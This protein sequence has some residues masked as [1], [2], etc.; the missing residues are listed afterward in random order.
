MEGILKLDGVD[1][2]LGAR[3]LEL[4]D[5][6]AFAF[7]YPGGVRGVRL[8]N[9]IGQLD[10][11]P[12]MGQQIWDA[13]FRGRRLTMRSM[14]SRP[15]KTGFFLHTYGCFM[16]H[17][18]ALRMGGP[19]PEDDHPLH[20]ELPCAGYR[21]AEL[22]F[23]EDDAGPWIAVSGTYEYDKAFQAH[24]TARPT[25]VLHAGSSLFDISLEISNRSSYPM[26]LM[27]MCHVNFV[28]VEG[29]RIVQST[30]WD[31]ESM[32]VRTSVPEHVSVSDE[33]LQFLEKLKTDPGLTRVLRSEDEYRPE[34]AFFMG[35]V[36]ADA[37]GRA[38]FLQVHP[39][40]TADY[41]SYRPGELDHATR[42]I[43][44]TG[45]QEALGLALPATCDPEGYTAEK[46]KGNL[47]SIEGEG[48]RAFR[49]T[50]GLLQQDEAARME[51]Y[52]GSIMGG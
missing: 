19:G 44:R 52:I 25:V 36:R 12:Y 33:F 13:M 4:G 17:C 42:W 18:G 45:D 43:M 26:D 11:L 28:P 50:T 51:R 48:R 8:D 21:D 30:G 1:F 5:L 2:T 20:G 15:R 6:S 31:P 38:H 35:Q 22:L 29:G 40:G 16:M 23:G 3:L 24:Y 46:E 7:T 9:G 32:R 10:I 49:V 27:Y 34:V 14:F 37:E 47:K 39:D 41:I